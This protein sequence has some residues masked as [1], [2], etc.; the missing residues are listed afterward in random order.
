MNFESRLSEGVFCIPECTECKKIVWP[1]AEFCS[2]CF[3]IVS[4]K[5]GDFEGKIIEFSS[6]ND[7]YFCLVEFENNIR[8]M[9]NILKIPDRGQSVKISKCGIVKDNYFFQV[10]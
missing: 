3:G 9:A 10:I 4:L 8:V 7:Q 6:Q 5:E 1:P 2:F